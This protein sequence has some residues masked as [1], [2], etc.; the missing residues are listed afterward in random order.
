MIDVLE[1]CF[2]AQLNS[3]DWQQKLKQLV[4]SYGESLIENAKLLKKVRQR[5][6]KTLGLSL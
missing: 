6:L 4:P 2:S 1:H 3:A 5:N